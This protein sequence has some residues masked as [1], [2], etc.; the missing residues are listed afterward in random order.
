M[1]TCDDATGKDAGDD[2]HSGS[3]DYDPRRDS[4]SYGLWPTPPRAL[5]AGARRI[6]GRF[7]GRDTGDGRRFGRRF[8]TR[9]ASGI[10]CALWCFTHR[11][12]IGDR[13]CAAGVSQRRKCFESISWQPARHFAAKKNIAIDEDA[14]LRAAE[15]VRVRSAWTPRLLTIPAAASLS[16][17]P[18]TPITCD[19]RANFGGQ[20]M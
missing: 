2:G 6:F 20:S 12:D 10:V 15:A 16:D 13:R 4:V 11:F 9:F 19:I 5:P 14:P 7:G 3:R 8:R 1:L 17:A 18:R